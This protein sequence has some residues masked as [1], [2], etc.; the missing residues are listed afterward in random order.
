L[1]GIISPATAPQTDRS[2]NED[3]QPGERHLQ[4][5]QNRWQHISSLDESGTPPLLP[6]APSACVVRADVSPSEER[7]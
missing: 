2:T 7:R 6:T 3:V 4:P 5:W 1:H